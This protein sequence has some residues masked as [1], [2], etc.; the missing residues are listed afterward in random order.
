MRLIINKLNN[1]IN[2][3]FYKMEKIGMFWGSTTGNQEEAANYLMDYMKSEGFEVDSFVSPSS[4]LILKTVTK[5]R[6]NIKIAK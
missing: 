2:K 4:T 6:Q 5:G 1:L 3:D